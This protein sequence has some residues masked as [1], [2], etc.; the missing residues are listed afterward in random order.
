MISKCCHQTLDRWVAVDILHRHR[1][2][3]RPLPEPST[4]LGHYQRIGPQIIKEMAINS[5][6]LDMQDASEHLRENPLDVLD[7]DHR[8]CI[9]VIGGGKCSQIGCRAIHRFFHYVSSL[10][11]NLAIR[12]IHLECRHLDIECSKT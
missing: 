7:V 4:E 8:V 12:D 9:A 5:H 1:R 3:I 10:K 2:H 6:L 11:Q